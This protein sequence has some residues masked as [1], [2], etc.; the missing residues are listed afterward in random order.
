MSGR[1]RRTQQRLRFDRGGSTLIGKLITVSKP[2]LRVVHVDMKHVR[3]ESRVPAVAR[4]P[5]A[6]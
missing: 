5:S 3:R 1:H 6:G 4:T 2:L